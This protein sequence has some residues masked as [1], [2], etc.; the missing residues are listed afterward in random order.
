MNKVLIVDDEE[1]ILKLYQRELIDEGYEVHTASNSKEALKIV[2]NNPLDLVVL[3][4][5]LKEENGLDTLSELRKLKKGMPIILNSAY[6]TYKSDFKSWLADAY[7]VKS[8]NL[9]ELKQKI[10]ELLNI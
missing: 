10:A 5:R 6:N 8:P 7:L 3:D 4:I 1:H 9:S 2:Q